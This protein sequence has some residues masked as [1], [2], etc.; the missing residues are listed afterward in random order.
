MFPH[1]G[2]TESWT[3]PYSLINFWIRHLIKIPTRDTKMAPIEKRHDHTKVC[4]PGLMVGVFVPSVLI[5][6]WLFVWWLTRRKP[7]R[8]VVG[9]GGRSPGGGPW[10]GMPP[11]YFG[12]FRGFGGRN[13]GGPSRPVRS[14][15]GPRGIDP[16]SP[17]RP[18]SH[19]R[20]S[21]RPPSAYRPPSRPPSAYR[22]PSRPRSSGIP[23]SRTPSKGGPR[24]GSSRDHVRDGIPPNSMY[25]GE[26]NPSPRA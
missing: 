5:F 10:T 6:S 12:S 13:P 16:T 14:S 23:L 11:P 7:Q 8:E 21:S 18:S 2:S 1:N 9:G 22:P 26:S 19:G 25:K 24:A 20:P 15:S 4:I 3:C 17:R